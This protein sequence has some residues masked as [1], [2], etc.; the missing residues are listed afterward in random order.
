MP[1][2][3]R[4]DADPEASARRPL[5]I[6]DAEMGRDD[7]SG[8]AAPVSPLSD[9]HEVVVGVV[10]NSVPRAAVL[11]QLEQLP[12]KRIVD[13][14]ESL[15]RLDP[16]RDGYRS[17]VTDFMDNIHVQ[18]RACFLVVRNAGHVMRV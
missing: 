8:L 3:R 7:L 6:L 4:R 1:D 2:W 5:G 15:H 14:V 12:G 17:V 13:R 18:G 16:P 11:M 10:A 9:P